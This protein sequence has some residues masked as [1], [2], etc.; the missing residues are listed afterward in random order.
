LFKGALHIASAL[1]L[2]REGMEGGRNTK[3]IARIEMAESGI[4]KKYYID[5]RKMTSDSIPRV[6]YTCEIS[7][8][9]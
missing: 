4:A 8:F 3:L 5:L 2:W 6:T 1:R 9:R 7:Y